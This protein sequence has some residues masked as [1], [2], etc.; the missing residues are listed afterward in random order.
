MKRVLGI[1]PA[2]GGSKGI[3][4]KN[5]VNL[6]G[7]PLISYTIEVALNAKT[8]TDVIVST[9][10]PVIQ[11]MAIALGA[12]APFLRPKELATDTAES[13]GVVLHALEYIEKHNGVEY[14]AIVLL[15]PTTPFRET[16]LIDKAVNTLFATGA[17]SVISVVDVGASHPIRM[18]TIEGDNNLVSFT[19]NHE[20][21]MMP[22]QS[23]PSVY[24]R[25]GCIYATTRSCIYNQST[26]IGE[27]SKALI[28]D[29]KYAINIDD[30]DDL[31]LARIKMRKQN[32]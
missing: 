25:S 14:D 10:S 17:D 1:V 12:E 32:T 22:R 24:I 26:L 9:D 28:V 4:N 5:I 20:R 31:E 30:H 6:N 8:L 3:K 13:Y 18:Y 11:R 29:K 19:G 2:R 23:L 27:I 21:S 7:K 15:Q 16:K